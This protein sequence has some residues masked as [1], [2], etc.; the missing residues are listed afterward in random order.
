MII[1]RTAL[2]REQALAEIA[3]LTAMASRIETRCGD[4]RLVW[5][6]W[7]SG[8]PLLLLHGG[9]GSWT[10]WIRN[11]EAFA[12]RGFQVIVPD[13]PGS[14]DS[15][16][17]PDGHDAD[18]IP[19]WLE[20][21]FADLPIADSPID[22]LAFSFGTLVGVLL[23]RDWPQ[24]VG[25][26]ILTGPPVLRR[27][28]PPFVGLRSW[29][30]AEPGPARDAVHRH[31]LGVFMFADSASI[32]ELAIETHGRNVERDRLTKRRLAQT[33]LMHDTIRRLDLPLHLI[34]G[35]LDVLYRDKWDEIHA[36]LD[37]VGALRSRTLIEN[38]GHWVAYEAADRYNA[39]VL[40]LLED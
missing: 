29:R 26:L 17:P 20:A 22:V 28:P 23:A 30:D 21:G 11:V 31:N 4:G 12:D 10:H 32:D 7:G 40:A 9:S 37:E 13:L 38:A 36:S 14:G 19:R 8:R 2:S 27:N 33:S 3:R 6:L 15:D 5:H 35:H 25:R 39:T 18:V 1:T 24:R 16:P 34:A